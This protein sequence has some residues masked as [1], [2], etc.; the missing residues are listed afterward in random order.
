MTID[1]RSMLKQV[2]GAGAIAALVGCIG[3]QEQGTEQPSN[4]SDGD[5]ESSE[6]AG[7]ATAWYGLSN[8]E[9]DLR[10]RAIEAFNEQSRHTVEGGN[11]SE[12]QDKTT[13][14]IPAGQGP[15]M[16]QWAHDW[17]GD[18][19]QR[20]FVIDQSDS[21]NLS[22]D[23]FTGAA[24]NA[25]QT[26]DA[27]VGLPFSAETVTL[28][29]N[30]DIVDSPPESFAEMESTM[31]SHHD[32]DNGQYGLAW[33]VDP[34][35]VSG[36]GQAFGGQY[37]DASQDDPVGLDSEETIR[38]FEFLVDNL[39][40]YMPNDPGYEPQQVAFLEGNA[41][42]AVNGPWYLAALRDSDTNFEVTTF[43]SLEGGEFTPL[44]G[45]KMW[46]FSKAME[47]DDANTAAAREF[48]EWFV[49]NEDHLLTRA[50]EQGHIPVL[51]TLAGSDDLPG[52]VRAYSQAVDQGIPM[53]TDPR[54]NDVFAA[55]GDPVTQLFNGSLS[56]EEALTS[57][58]EEARSQW[59]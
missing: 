22:L 27:V 15:Q 14:A 20:G 21:L 50:E 54:M 42:F 46:Y 44:S 40:Q 4:S 18:Y 38:G 24:A 33:P 41:A 58:A 26:D 39:F 35:F 48:I 45:I 36:V 37:F 19:Y 28:I 25:V 49:T 53:P 34:Y 57:A 8:T 3:V 51:S 13:S 29:Y 16:F 5:T 7:T 32:P 55:M 23:Q 47:A 2:G 43:P 12:M 52:P 11:I 59:E 10:E 6:P 9:L 56:P 31:E 1:R 17:V 30:T